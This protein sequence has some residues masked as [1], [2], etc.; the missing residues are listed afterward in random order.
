MARPR[1]ARPVDGW[2]VFAA[3]IMF[4]VG[5]H[6]LIYGLATLSEYSVVMANLD[7]NGVDTGLIYA[8]RPFWGWLWIAV[9]VLQLVISYGIVTGNQMAR[10]G[11]IAL[12]TINAIGQL[13]FLAAFPVW[14]VIIIAIDLLVIWALATYDSRVGARGSL[15]TPYPGDR[16][17]GG[18]RAD[19]GATRVGSGSTTRPGGSSGGPH[20]KS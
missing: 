17:G 5:F 14:S 12:A 16:P 4:I 6:N 1:H 2:L 7:V 18:R 8:D 10:W 3:V 15:Q 13:A 9:G 19:T 11:G 20:P